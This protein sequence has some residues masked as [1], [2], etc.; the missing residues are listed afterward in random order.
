M[1]GRDA[2]CKISQVA[3]KKFLVGDACR[4]Y[5]FP[6]HPHVVVARSLQYTF[7]LLGLRTAFLLKIRTSKPSWRSAV[8]CEAWEPGEVRKTRRMIDETENTFARHAFAFR[9]KLCRGPEHGLAQPISGPNAEPGSEECD[10]DAAYR[11]ANTTYRSADPAYRGAGPRGSDSAEYS[12]P[13]PRRRKLGHP[14]DTRYRLFD[15]HGRYAFPEHHRRTGPESGGPES[16]FA[17]E[18][19][20]RN[21]WDAIQSNW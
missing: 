6:C 21:Y 16:R 7:L 19:P 4:W 12:T 11:S 10:A 5:L 13:N 1:G 15:R 3:G 18:Q 17:F 9:S 14:G 8:R 20:R 2:R